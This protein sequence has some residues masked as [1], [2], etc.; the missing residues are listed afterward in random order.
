MKKQYQLTKFD[1][2]TYKYISFSI[3]YSRPEEYL[4]DVAKELT[5]KKFK[6]YILFDLLL[7]NGLNAQRYVKSYFNGENFQF[8]S[9]S[10]LSDKELDENIKKF[11]F[12][13]YSSK[14]ELLESSNLLSRAQK[15]LVRKNFQ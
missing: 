6:G 14:S 13:F 3:D 11:T 7:C 9:F 2:D 1:G 12:N 4:S 8:D 15:F 5:R 10:T